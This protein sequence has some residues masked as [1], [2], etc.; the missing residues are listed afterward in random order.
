LEGANKRRNDP[1]RGSQIERLKEE[2]RSA[3]HLLAFKTM[4]P[5]ELRE[6]TRK[7]EAMA[8]DRLLWESRREAEAL[9][10]DRKR[11]QMR[12]SPNPNPNWRHFEPIERGS[13]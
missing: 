4:N 10:A 13:R 11:E 1:K 2:L 8:R 12:P 7:E 9:R 6:L 3:E 5:E